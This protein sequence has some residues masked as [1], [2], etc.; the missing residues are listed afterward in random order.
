MLF[1]AYSAYV[2]R[3]DPA[4]LP[5]ATQVLD[6]RGLVEAGGAYSNWEDQAGA[7]DLEQPIAGSRPDNDAT[8][9]G[10][11]APNFDGL[12]DYMAGPVATGGDAYTSANAG[13][14]F[15]VVDTTGEVMPPDQVDVYNEGAIFALGNSARWLGLTWTASGPRAYGFDGA[16]KTPARMDQTLGACLIDIEY[17]G[18][19]LSSRRGVD[20]PT[21][22]ACG[23]LQVPGNRAL[24][25]CN[26]NTAAFF[27]GRIASVI[28][29]NSAL[30][31]AESALVRSY[32]SR[33]YGVPA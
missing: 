26:Y 25:G 19:T 4:L 12:N 3:W 5:Q 8:V 24:Y 2:R 30:T 6:Q 31:A 23:P 27:P 15:V 7:L 20:A 29:Y 16:W 13:R 11:P 9:N 18:V 33:K 22:V 1:P 21:T 17:D 14:V 10:L 28:M 32:L